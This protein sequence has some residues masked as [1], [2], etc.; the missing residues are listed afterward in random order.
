MA[1]TPQMPQAQPPQAPPPYRHGHP[2]SISGPIVLIVIGVLFLLEKMGVVHWG[3]LGY[4]FAHYWPLLLI[5][6]GLVKLIEHLAAQ[7]SG[8]P[9]PGLGVGGAILVVAIIF[10]GLVASQAMRVDWDSLRDQIQMGDNDFPFFGHKYSYEDQLA[11]AF[12]PGGNLHVTDPRG[13][14]NITVSDDNQ[15]HVAVHKRLNADNQELADKW[16]AGSRPQITVSGQNVTL[17]ANT[18]GAGDHGVNSDL[19]ISIP[20]KASVVVSADHGDASVLGRDGDVSVSARHGDV[21]ITDINGNVRLDL[22]DSSAHVATVSSDVNVQGKA[23]DVSLEDIKGTVTLDGD[24]MESLRLARLSKPLNFKSARTQID[25]TRLDGDLDLD[26]GDL[27]ITNVVGPVHV[28]TKFKDIGLVGVSGDLRLRNENGAV[29]IQMTKMGSMDVE[30]QNADITIG[31]PPKAAFQLDARS[32]GGEIDSDFHGLNVQNGD[33]QSTA[34][35][36]VGSGGPH[37]VINNQHGSIEIRQGAIEANDDEPSVPRTPKPP[38]GPNP[39]TVTD[40]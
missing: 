23:Q 40:N 27:R 20:R 38:P 37:V 31:V 30:N 5:F 13:A 11:Q 25:F 12:P 24:F 2:R 8:A 35:G 32:H 36:S 16:N 17:N 14:V 34:A 18:Q 7:R 28:S 15:I 1:S 29:E 19:D 4:L 22:Q 10:W 33:E 3:N 39:P 6:F 26:S 9:T 21:A